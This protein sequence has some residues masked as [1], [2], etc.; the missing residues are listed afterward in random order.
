[1]CNYMQAEETT[2]PP[3]VWRQRDARSISLEVRA[4]SVT[5]NLNSRKRAFSVTLNS[6][7]RACSVMPNHM[8]ACRTAS[9]GCRRGREEQ[10]SGCS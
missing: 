7:E 8:A 2:E 1:M 6:R 5:P 4:F 10:E 3:M 9:F